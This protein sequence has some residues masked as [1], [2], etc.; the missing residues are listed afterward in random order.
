MEG[1]MPILKRRKS[2]VPEGPG[3]IGPARLARRP[4]DLSTVRA[5]D[6]VVLD[7]VDLSAES[8]QSLVERGVAAVVNVS[9]SSSGRFPNLGPRLLVEAGIVLVD[10]VGEAVW[11]TLRS[12][13]VVRVHEG[14]VFLGETT[15]ATGIEMT[16]V[17]VRDQLDEASSGLTNQLDSIVTNAANT[18][19]RD[20]AMLLEGAGIPAIATSIKDRP[21][22]VVSDG[23]DAAADLK[24]IR[25]FIRDHDPVLVGVGV[26][27]ELLL[28]R[29]LRPHLLV[30]RGDDLSGR[31]IERSGEVVIVSPSGRLDRPEQFEAHGLQPVVF[32]AAGA[33]ENLAVLLADQ[34]EAAVIVQVGAPSRL[35]D[36]VDGDT[37][38]AAGTF[39]ARLRAG[40]RVVDAQA[41][42][43]F[44]RQRLSWFIP[45]LLLLAGVVAVVAAVATTPLGHEWL[46]P[47]TDSVTSWIEGLVS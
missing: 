25:S 16:S 4:D 17:R 22:V 20:R 39:I 6:V 12:G 24:A 9:T 46:S 35:V 41:V 23:P 11:Q 38:D 15:I 44:A 37:A 13:D 1:I 26:G 40:S 21:V 43:W 42:A 45:V 8:A 3:V 31:A 34:N 32:T 28:D 7:M 14:A 18:L 2:A 47:V 19:R 33:P 29:G 5:G 30:G 10:R 27:A 36:V